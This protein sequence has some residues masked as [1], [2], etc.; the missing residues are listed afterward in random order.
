MFIHLANKQTEPS[1]LST[2]VRSYQYFPDQPIEKPNPNVLPNFCKDYNDKLKTNCFDILPYYYPI[3]NDTNITTTWQSFQSFEEYYNCCN[4]NLTYSNVKN[5]NEL[6]IV[7]YNIW[8]DTYYSKERTNKII[9]LCQE[10][11][12]DII[13]LQEVT[14]QTLNIIC[15]HPFIKNNFIVSDAE[16]NSVRPYGVWIAVKKTVPMSTF[17]VNTLPTEMG[18]SALSVELL[19]P[20]S[21]FSNSSINDNNFKDFNRK[22]INKCCITTVHLESLNNEHYRREQLYLISTFLK[23][24]KY[25]F[26][27]GDFNFD[28]ERNFTIRKG[29]LLE[30][31]NLNYFYEE[32]K[33]L[34]QVLKK[35]KNWEDKGKTFDTNKNLMLYNGHWVEVMRYDRMLWKNNEDDWQVND[36]EIIGD[37]PMLKLGDEMNTQWV[38]PSDHFGLFTTIKK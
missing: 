23:P 14:F 5:I 22:I 10:K 17:F 7:S 28:D 8:F 34:W 21:I 4:Q 6:K 26:L 37:K 11:D 24:Y 33:D 18:R 27:C 15:N 13:C 29:E 12:V 16:G 36:I 38:Y 31:F 20:S 1:C 9:D 3:N 35:E 2:Q 32:Y 30:N 19:L 25:S